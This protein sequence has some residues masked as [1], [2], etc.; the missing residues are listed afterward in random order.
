[1]LSFGFPPLISASAKTLVLGTLPSRISLSRS[2]YYANPRNQFWMITGA[3]IS[4][5]LASNYSGRVAQ[6][7]EYRVALWDVLAAATRSGSMDADISDDAIPNNFPALF[8]AY[9]NIRLIGFNGETAAAL[10]RRHVLPRLSE[11][12]RSI[13]RVTLPST[14]PAHAAMSL[15]TKIQRWAAVWRHDPQ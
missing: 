8:R 6:L 11:E 4:V 14:S 2:E 7:A 13:E 5:E 1:M 12:H 3:A 10:Y 9:P 15:D